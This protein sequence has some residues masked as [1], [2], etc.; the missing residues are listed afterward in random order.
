LAS[1]RDHRVGNSAHESK[2]LPKLRQ[3]IRTKDVSTG[4]QKDIL[5]R[6]VIAAERIMMVRALHEAVDVPFQLF[7]LADEIFEVEEPQHEPLYKKG[8][9]S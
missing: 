5:Y 6:R 8:L 3:S 4:K 9:I 7:S 2:V 1:R